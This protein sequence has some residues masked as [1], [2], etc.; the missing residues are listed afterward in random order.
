MTGAIVPLRLALLLIATLSLVLVVAALLGGDL[1][2]R[3]GP[4]RAS[5]TTPLRP[6]FFAI[7]CAAIAAMARPTRRDLTA[8]A[9]L[10]YLVVALSL[11]PLAVIHGA[12]DVWPVGDLALIELNVRQALDF[13]RYLG[14][15]SQYG[16]NHPGP[17]AY[18]A[19]TPWYV[20]GGGSTLAL[21]A[22]AL[23]INVAAIVTALLTVMRRSAASPVVALSMA[24]LLS[25]YIFRTGPL[26]TSA[27]NPHA[28]VYP[29][30]AY[31]VFAAA[32]FQRTTTVS[33]LAAVGWGSYCVQLH[34]GVAA[35]VGAIAIAYVL[36]RIIWRASRSHLAAPLPF[37]AL[38][39]FAL[40]LW[41]FPMAEQL[42]HRPGNVIRTLGFF[43][44][45]ASTHSVSTALNAWA[46]MLLGVAR[47][48]LA[49][50]QG[51]EF[52][53]PFRIVWPIA[54]LACTG[55]LLL[56][57]VRGGQRERSF[58]GAAAW[59]AF[60]AV[61]VGLWST[62]QIRGPIADH[63]VFWLSILGVF[64]LAVVMGAIA[65]RA[66]GQADGAWRF[67]RVV[68][69]LPALF[70]GSVG[71]LEL[72]ESTK[73]SAVVGGESSAVRALAARV[74]LGLTEREIHKPLFEIRQEAWGVAAG[75]LLQLSKRHVP[76]AVDKA[77]FVMYGDA[78][79]PDGSEDARVIIG[80]SRSMRELLISSDAEFL[81]DHQTV[82][83]VV[84]RD[85]HHRS[86]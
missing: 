47:T 38:V 55:G 81:A 7:A 23:A 52:V 32:V 50:P 43:S 33:L 53:P 20:L 5:A 76:F 74:R 15:Y 86:P 80:D 14:A 58:T 19:M 34:I 66:V 4:F 29:L 75:V 69:V 46:H 30:F 42:V 10:F 65:A 39:C 27:W 17:L 13:H 28:L 24:V 73:A 56:V 9:A 57:A 72:T 77:L 41:A 61:V 54:A 49:V 6:L 59:V 11:A 3:V 84:T 60:L 16:W 68:L 51:W 25:I 2:F 21:D 45:H 48:E 85:R 31:L 8:R 35:I 64:G 82:M 1:R 62:L 44:E 18:Y 63:A 12:N 79:M 70:A 26:I 37:G 40:A 22:A 83:A 71:L 36:Q 67:T 78:L